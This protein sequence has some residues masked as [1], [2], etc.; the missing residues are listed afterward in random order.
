MKKL[1]LS[2]IVVFIGLSGISQV[3]PQP[4]GKGIN[5]VGKDGSYTM[6]FGIRFQTLYSNEW[7]V[8]QDELGNIGDYKSNFLIRRARLKFN[9]YVLNPKVKYKIELGLSNRDI[10]GANK[11]EHNY[12]PKFILDAFIDWNFY[13]NFSLKFGQSKLPGNRERVI[14]SA[15][16]QFVDRSRLNSR[17]NIDRDFGLQLK[18]HFTIGE[19][20]IIKEAFAFTQGEGRNITM[21]NQGGFDYTF[22]VEL[23][24]FGKFQSKGD[25]VSSA[26]KLE[27][28]PKLAIGF[29]YDINDGAVKERG[30]NGSFIMDSGGNYVGKTLNTF[31]ADFMFKYKNLSVLGEYAIKDTDDG[32]PHVFEG[33]DIIGTYYLGTGLNIQAGWMFD[34][35]VEIAGRYTSINTD[36]A[37]AN[38]EKEYT[39]AMSKF[40]VGHKLKVQGDISYRNKFYE[41]GT[42][43]NDKLYW[44]MQFDIHF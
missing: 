13:K 28:K 24:P 15:N 33:N 19:N 25:Y 36:I 11:S 20:F 4:F 34:N 44:R 41:T 3:N 38:S 18:H 2:I 37:I 35:H 12:A 6:K 42:Q 23:L 43:V 29:T 31:F 1:I 16:L 39:L 32:S 17:F 22:R 10:G 7:T 14:S 21:G 30:Q 8:R 9:G 5:I 40:F 27:E 26:I